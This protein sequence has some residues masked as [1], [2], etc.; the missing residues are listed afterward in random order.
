MDP[1]VGW[2]SGS[3]GSRCYFY[4]FLDAFSKTWFLL[5]HKMEMKFNRVIGTQPSV[6]SRGRPGYIL[7]IIISINGIYQLSAG[8][9]FPSSYQLINTLT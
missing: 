7:A 5:Y 6:C 2:D 4:N 9:Y 1:N 3:S 8:D